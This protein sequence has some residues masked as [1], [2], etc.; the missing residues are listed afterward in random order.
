MADYSDLDELFQVDEP[1]GL[2]RRVAIGTLIAANDIRM[3]TDDGSLRM[4][5][6]KR[7]AQSILSSFI[8]ANHYVNSATDAALASHPIFEGIYRSVIGANAG[9]SVAT[10]QAATDASIKANVDD[11]VDLLA[12]TFI[13]P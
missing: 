13:D 12:E 3:E 7:F 9:S 1:S 11:A 6:R 4:K 2:R 5:Q 10:I 8:G